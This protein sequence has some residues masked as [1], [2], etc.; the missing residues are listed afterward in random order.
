MLGDDDDK[1]RG[2]ARKPARKLKRLAAVA[3]ATATL[4]V[5]GVVTAN[6]D[7]AAQSQ[8]AASTSQ[9]GQSSQTRG[10]GESQ[11]GQGGDPAPS[12]PQ[13][14]YLGLT[15][16]VSGDGHSDPNALQSGDVFLYQFDLRCSESNCV[17]VKLTDT[18]PAQL[19]GFQI[20]DLRVDS[21][22]RGTVAWKEGETA[23]G[24]QPAT[25]GNA[26]S[27]EVTPGQKFETANGVESGLVV[28]RTGT[29][30][31]KLKVPENFSPDDSRAHATIANSSTLSAANSKPCN[32]TSPI[33]MDVE[34]LLKGAS[35]AAFDPTTSPYNAGGAEGL[36]LTVTNGSN[37]KVDK[38]TVQV[39]QDAGAADNAQQL[40]ESNPFRYFDF[41][42]FPGT[43]TVMPAGATK[44]EVDA[45]VKDAGTGKWK[46]VKGTAAN[47]FALPASVTAA[48]K[49]G[50]LRFVYTGAMNS[51]ATIPGG[52]HIALKLK[53]R[54]SDRN[55]ATNALFANLTTPT[56]VNATT[57][58]SVAK[59]AQA[60]D[61][62]ASD[63]TSVTLS[64]AELNVS[65]SESFA[66]GS[67]PAGNKA[68]ATLIVTNGATG[69]ADKMQVSAGKDFFDNDITFGGFDA[70]T[71]PNG[72]SGGKVVYHMLD[73][74][75]DQTVTFASGAV[76]AAP[77]GKIKSFDVIFTSTPTDTNP[78][79]IAAGAGSTIGYT[80]KS[81][82]DFSFPSGQTSK[83]FT[84]KPAA[85][86]FAHNGTNKAADA[87]PATMTLVKP[88]VRVT[89]NKT[90]NPTS[91][92]PMGQKAVVALQEHTS[93]SSDYLRPRKL[94]VED[95]WVAKSL[96]SSGHVMEGTANDS[97]DFWNAFDINSIQSTQVPSKTSLKVEVKVDGSWVTLDT[98]AETPDSHIYSLSNADLVSKLSAAHPGA[99]PSDV[100]GIR[101]TL[102]AEPGATPFSGATAVSQYVCF[103]AREQKRDGSGPTDVLDNKDQKPTSYT[104]GTTTSL[105]AQGFTDDDQAN[106]IVSNAVDSDPD[107]SNPKTA[108]IIVYKKVPP[109]TGE[110]YYKVNDWIAA[111]FTD[112]EDSNNP[113]SAMDDIPSQSGRT[114]TAHL[115]WGVEQN[116]KNVTLKQSG[117]VGPYL[118]EP[119]SSDAW[120]TVFDL[121]SIEPIDASDAAAYTNGWY[122]KYDVITKIRLYD[123]ETRQW[124][125]ANPTDGSGQWQS[126][127]GSFKGYTLSDD[128]AGKMTGIEYSLKPNVARRAA[129]LAAGVPYTPAVGSDE[130]HSS[131]VPSAVGEREFASTWKIRNVRKD[132]AADCLVVGKTPSND[133]MHSQPQRVSLHANSF[134]A[135]D[136]VNHPNT[137]AYEA[138]NGSSINI[139]DFDA[140]VKEGDPTTST[141]VVPPYGASSTYPTQSYDF[142][143]RN[144][145]PNRA[146]YLRLTV[147]SECADGSLPRCYTPNT[148]AGAKSDPFTSARVADMASGQL[149]S[150]DSTPNM[151]NRQ[152][153]TKIELSSDDPGQVSL[154]DSVVYILHYTPTDYVNGKGTFR[155]EPMTAAAANALT[156]AQLKD[157]VGVSVTFQ[158]PTPDVTGATLTNDNW[159]HIKVTTRAR[160]AVRSTNKPF[161][162]D[163]RHAGMVTE[164]ET[165]TTAQI[166]APA[167]YTRGPVGKFVRST[168]SYKTGVLKTSVSESIDPNNVLKANPQAPQTVTMN[169]DSTD[170]SVASTL[171]PTK[172][173]LTS[174]PDGQSRATGA[175]KTGEFWK[176][177]DFTGLASITF[178][179][180]AT[181]VKIGVYGPFGAGGAMAWKD[182]SDQ[183]AVTAPATYDLPVPAAQYGQIQGLRFVFTNPGATTGALKLFSSSTDPSWSAQVQYKV[184][185]RQQVRGGS[186]EVAYPGDTLNAA[187]S[188]AESRIGG[189]NE[190][191][192]ANADTAA[193]IRW[194]LGT[195]ELAL[196]EV[197]NGANPDVGVGDLV[198]WDVTIANSGTGYIN[199]TTMTAQVPAHL[200]YTGQGGYDGSQP[201]TSFT[202]GEVDE[203]AGS[204]DF[205]TAPSVASDGTANTVTF[206]WQ[207]GKNR[208]KPGER[209]VVRLW[210]EVE[211]G[212][213]AGNPLTLP[214]TVLTEQHL[215]GTGPVAGTS[216]LVDPVLDA[217]GTNTIGAKTTAFVQT[218]SGEKIYI[219]EGV[220]GARSG[221]VNTIDSAQSCAPLL[222]G[223]DGHSYYRAPCRANTAVGGTDDWALHMV[224]AGSTSFKQAQFFEQLPASHDKMIA[225]SGN[226]RG[227]GYRPELTKAPKVVGAP[228]GTT[229]IIEVTTAAQACVG[230]WDTLPGNSATPANAACS[231]D[232]W[233]VASSGTD[234]SQVTGLRVTLDFTG[235]S[236]G[237][238]NPGESADV[239]YTT[240]NVPQ[241]TVGTRAQTDPS[242]LASLD[243]TSG[244]QEAWSQFGL[245]YMDAAGT[246][247][248]TA[249][250]K[251]GTRIATGSVSVTKK[252]EGATGYAPARIN[253]AVSCK[254]ADGDPMTFGGRSQGL[255]ALNRKG[256]GTYA[257]GRISG[258]PMSVDA[259]GNGSTSCVVSEEGYTGQFGEVKRVVEV[260][261][262]GNTSDSDT[263][264]IESPDTLDGDNKPTNEVVDA[265]SALITNTY[266]PPSPSNGDGSDSRNGKGRMGSTGAAIA[267]VV[268][269]VIVL[270]VAGGAVWFIRKRHENRG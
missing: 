90:V 9:S 93:T 45:Y 78:N 21:D 221:A 129:D 13:Y 228:D 59:G 160:A 253:G 82:H 85:K 32:G 262:D 88:Q 130:A 218:Q 181:K 207:Q 244:P 57:Q 229:K 254:D 99:T 110:D 199:I 260:N 113:G 177:F 52:G 27:F 61:S 54:A 178:P 264:G 34:T 209:A 269:V 96:D 217:T 195:A 73:G 157:V 42:G 106:P 125:V 76:P 173:T 16:T 175:T 154:G 114:T 94:V 150:D 236:A 216:A 206:T 241:G 63:P 7:D 234:W 3:A 205:N 66:P 15:Q 23:L 231:A 117:D 77:S 211:P 43:A 101:F 247:S 25:V 155:S 79:P 87:E 159:V 226:D 202:P 132:C 169:A 134:V 103:T 256:D 194:S 146:S 204:G 180:G 44:V 131:V 224:N 248:P 261:G 36:N 266:V 238:L 22:L 37:V 145:A 167:T 156:E 30:T 107:P 192:T 252:V 152:D 122:L 70:I 161:I 100:V 184:V 176:D 104:Y 95:S 143:A 208:M 2:S 65:V 74:S 102:E 233:T 245:L 111:D 72:A 92:I 185:Q 80:V 4:L 255:V 187:S 119:A 265:Q 123:S 148:A 153:I 191:Q 38:L 5:G 28:N 144:D 126:A 220:K 48:S 75:A 86:V 251:V 105:N 240:R 223:L 29:V 267:A 60:S 35:T 198:P 39:P 147:P 203:V 215:D 243:Q 237:V 158:S 138:V 41:A 232:A 135:E 58:S 164:D 225:A 179:D 71:Y 189:G 165:R 170:I 69:A 112:P 20:V 200:M 242:V 201:P 258:I 133:V 136:P 6:A 97:D 17:D 230:T 40:G 116:M 214:V 141:I 127:N 239:V 68:K 197:A 118:D 140:V 26:T 83:A 98:S 24:S 172:V 190:D 235:T 33:T 188:E 89:V 53:Q 171:S 81:P 227:S 210:L 56:T 67:H 142:K 149:D 14:K 109:T 47:T 222:T 250:E 124:V 263:M 121:Q 174:W 19:H 196:N 10:G 186:Q 268:V 128:E 31:L 163:G 168:V 219:V 246:Q 120:G 183:G 64:P 139:K 91:A 8:P 50:G 137:L 212:A 49:V 166:Y 12:E 182:G 151:F 55:D 257:P 51:G 213:V 62:V 270:L 108:K 115:K 1:A 11:P 249:T 84:D 162:P 18:L 259:S 193:Q 46:W